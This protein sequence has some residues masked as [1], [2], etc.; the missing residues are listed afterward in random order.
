MT[1]RAGERLIA[2]PRT[3]GSYRLVRGSCALLTPLFPNLPDRLEGIST[4]RAR[5]S[6]TSGDDAN[7]S[8]S[9]NGPPDWRQAHL[10][11]RDREPRA[12]GGFEAHNLAAMERG[13]GSPAHQH[14]LRADPRL[15][16]QDRGVRKITWFN[17]RYLEECDGCGGPSAD[18]L[19]PSRGCSTPRARSR[20]PGRQS[21]ERSSSTLHWTSA[22]T[23]HGS[24]SMPTSARR[25]AFFGL[26]L[27]SAL[28]R[29]VWRNA[30]FAP[31]TADPDRGRT[32]SPDARCV[33]FAILIP[34]ARRSL[35]PNPAVVGPSRASPVG[36]P[37]GPGQRL[38]GVLDRH[39][40][41]RPCAEPPQ[42]FR[43]WRR[44]NDRTRIGL[45]RKAISPRPWMLSGGETCGWL[46]GPTPTPTGA[47]A[48]IFEISAPRSPRPR[49]FRIGARR[50][51][52]L[53]STPFERGRLAVIFSIRYFS[54]GCRMRPMPHSGA[55]DPG[56][57][58]I[59]S[60]SSRFCRSGDE[61]TTPKPCSGKGPGLFS[62]SSTGRKPWSA[63]LMLL[64]GRR[65][66]ASIH[67]AP[68]AARRMARLPHLGR[69]SPNEIP[70]PPPGPDPA[71]EGTG[72]RKHTATDEPR[73]S[74]QAL[75][76][77]APIHTAALGRRV[78]RFRLCDPGT[79]FCLPRPASAR[80]KELFARAFI[81]ALTGEGDVPSPTYHA[82]ADLRGP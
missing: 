38:F 36:I 69:P 2:T 17:R 14:R 47:I 43:M 31:F 55:F 4:R 60:R 53:F 42:L 5:R 61:R 58:G 21:K 63:R 45:P 54:P 39:A 22:M 73:R 59:R 50:R 32:F 33:G 77:R 40:I 12:G 41:P 9:P 11:R 29:Q 23:S 75:S 62:S 80:G 48:F 34:A 74:L 30:S 68:V 13:A 64:D 44:R 79:P 49:R 66:T 26:A 20:L 46:S 15:A 7:V 19:A 37:D 8:D 65:P 35:I 70:F 3:V 76:R 51:A 56:A 18:R 25:G 72:A 28:N 57:C 67:S 16:A 27:Q 10:D 1:T 78:L 24:T 81:G 82:R 52:R 71:C 6:F